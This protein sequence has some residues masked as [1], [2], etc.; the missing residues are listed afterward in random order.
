MLDGKCRI[1]NE[2]KSLDEFLIE[3]EEVRRVRKIID[4]NFGIEDS[5][6]DTLFG[7]IDLLREELQRRDATIGDLY[8]EIFQQES[9][10][11]YSENLLRTL[12]LEK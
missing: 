5:P 8:D 9:R 10:A 1:M 4:E 6:F 3:V 11:E 7:A 2:K 12:N